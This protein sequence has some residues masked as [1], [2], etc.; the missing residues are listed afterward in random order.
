VAPKQGFAGFL[1]SELGYGARPSAAQWWGLGRCAAVAEVG[2]KRK[3]MMDWWTGRAGLSETPFLYFFVVFNF[4][5]MFDHLF[6]SKY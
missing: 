1:G 4:L 5:F 2:K 3:E 6:Y